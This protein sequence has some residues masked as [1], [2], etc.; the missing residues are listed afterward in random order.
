MLIHKEVFC[1]SGLLRPNLSKLLGTF[2]LSFAQLYQSCATKCFSGVGSNFWRSACHLTFSAL[3]L[4][5]KCYL[6]ISSVL[7]NSSSSFSRSQFYKW[8]KSQY[9]R[10]ADNSSCMPWPDSASRLFESTKLVTSRSRHAASSCIYCSW[11]D[12][13]YCLS[14]N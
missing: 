2:S 7:T 11:R 8:S 13:H 10:I 1:R 6:S 4:R 12:L 3:V 14:K 5:S 9:C